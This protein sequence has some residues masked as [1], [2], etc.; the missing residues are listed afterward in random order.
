M[1]MYYIFC[2]SCCPHYIAWEILV[3][4]PGIK[5]MHLQWKLGVPTTEL[6]GKSPVF[7]IHLFKYLVN[8][9]YGQDA[10]LEIKDSQRLTS[11]IF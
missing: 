11:L 10:I 8:T 7:L 1:T 2:C 4:S 6:L 5:P 3:P 9:S